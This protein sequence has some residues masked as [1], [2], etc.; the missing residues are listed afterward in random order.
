MIEMEYSPEQLVIR[1][2]QLEDHDGILNITS[3]EELYR[4]MDYL[5][6]ALKSWLKEGADE[7]SNRENYVFTLIGNIVGFVSIYFQNAGKVAVK[8][9]FRVSKHIRGKGYGRQITILLEQHLKKNHANL[10][11]TVSSISDMDLT[12]EEINSPKHGKLLAVKS[13]PTYKIKLKDLNGLSSA[14]TCKQ[15]S[16]VVSKKNSLRY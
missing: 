10:E 2:G 13:Y 4:G 11:S 8:F 14:E 6:F 7:K 16:Y 1:Q 12:D 5:P 15:K 9:A 3:Q